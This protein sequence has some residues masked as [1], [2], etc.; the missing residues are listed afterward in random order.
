LKARSEDK[1]Q[2]KLDRMKQHGLSRDPRDVY[3]MNKSM[4]AAGLSNNGNG[5]IINNDMTTN[6]ALFL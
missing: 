1:Y 6:T 4:V 3:A 2:E 5:N